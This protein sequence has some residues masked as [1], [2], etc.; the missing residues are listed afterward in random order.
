LA[1]ACLLVKVLALPLAQA[2]QHIPENAIPI[3]ISWP[4]LQ[5]Q[6]PKAA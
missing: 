6:N 5:G 4:A 2:R 3:Y 1:L